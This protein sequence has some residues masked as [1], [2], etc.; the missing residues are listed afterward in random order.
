MSAEAWTRDAAEAREWT[1]R[2]RRDA[3]VV[4]PDGTLRPLY[5]ACDRLMPLVLALA[6]ALCALPGVPREARREIEA[7]AR[8]VRENAK[9]SHDQT[10]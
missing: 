10:P 5:P 9:G 1:D 4:Q 3:L 6:D 8:E 2:C 7:L